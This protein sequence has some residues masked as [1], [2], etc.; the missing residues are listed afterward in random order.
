VTRLLR[1]LE[2]VE[3]RVLGALRCVDAGTGA[4]IATPLT[5]RASLVVR[6]SFATAAGST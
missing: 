3:S 5:L 6:I 2:R 4:D 1:E